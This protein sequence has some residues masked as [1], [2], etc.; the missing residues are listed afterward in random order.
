MVSP[1]RKTKLETLTLKENGPLICRKLVISE[2]IEKEVQ[3]V[4]YSSA[5]KIKSERV[6]D[7]ATLTGSYTGT[8]SVETDLKAFSLTSASH[9]QL[10]LDCRVTR[11]ISAKIHLMTRKASKPESSR[12]PGGNL[13]DSFRNVLGQKLAL[14]AI[15]DFLRETP[16]TLYGV[17]PSQSG[18]VWVAL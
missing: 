4:P 1:S 15:Y 6:P 18:A 7:G 13:P 10:R 8:S 9:Q 11:Y 12:E 3:Y 16:I 2:A 5:K 17:A 14:N